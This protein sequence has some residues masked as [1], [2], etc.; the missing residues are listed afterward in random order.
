MNWN[1]AKR[2]MCL[3]TVEEIEKQLGDSKSTHVGHIETEL[4]AWGRYD[5]INAMHDEIACNMY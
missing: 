2:K 4:I 1:K 5:L 3:D